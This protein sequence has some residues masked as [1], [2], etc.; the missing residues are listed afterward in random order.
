ME[1]LGRAQNKVIHDVKRVIG[2]LGR[3]PKVPGHRK[4]FEYNVEKDELDRLI[5][6][7]PAGRAAIKTY[8]PEQISAFILAEMRRLA[9]RHVGGRTVK[10]AVVTVPAY[11]NNQQRQATKDAAKIAGLEIL[12]IINEPTA[13]AL[14]Y[15]HRIDFEA[16]ETR[17]LLMFDFGGGTFDV[18]VLSV[19]DG[20]LDVL[21]TRGDSH[22]GGRD[23]DNKIRDY[24]I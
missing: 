8:Y 21:A 19:A 6:N 23:I 14:A 18:T 24:C 3:D 7:V 12:R 20:V 10:K 1:R 13:A 17:N 16:E 22:L 2:R 5:I 11:F 15:S 4:N 9:E